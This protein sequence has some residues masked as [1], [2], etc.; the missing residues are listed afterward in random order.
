MIKQIFF[1]LV[2]FFPIFNIYAWDTTPPTA[3]EL[4]FYD[5]DWN[6]KID[7]IYIKFNET[8]TW[9]LVKSVFRISSVAWAFKEDSVSSTTDISSDILSSLIIWT[10]KNILKVRI[11]DFYKTWTGLIITN[12]TY[13]ELR[14]KNNLGVWITDLAW[15]EIDLSLTDSF[16]EYNT[17]KV[18]YWTYEEIWCSWDS[19][20]SIEIEK[21]QI[22]FNWTAL[23]IPLIANNF[24]NIW[25]FELRFQYD[26]SQ[27]N[28]QSVDS[29]ILNS[30]W[31]LQENFS[32][33]EINLIWDEDGW[34][35]LN[36]W[37]WTL[38]EI[39]CNVIWN[40]WDSSNLILTIP[41]L[42]DLDWNDLQ[43][44]YQ[45]TKTFFIQE[46][47]TIWWK[48]LN[49]DWSVFTWWTALLK[50]QDNSILEKISNTV[51]FLFWYLI[52]NQDYE[53]SAKINEWYTEDT[54]WTWDILKIQKHIIKSQEFTSWYDC[55]AADVN[56]DWKISVLDIIKIRKYLYN[57]T[58]LPSWDFKFYTWNIS[59]LNLWNL[60]EK[61]II[62]NFQSSTWNLIF[63]K[64]RMWNVEN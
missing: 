24:Q 14:V 47:F 44:N 57:K 8:L 50:K 27:L 29:E 4:R 19:C 36:F 42:W 64:I 1:L 15:N 49:P 21:N 52:A 16:N 10:S 2:L 32:D 62:N 7:T 38:L 33:W 5:S 46:N 25:W 51:W 26:N 60:Q 41:E 23:K 37:S 20:I 59:C 54:V 56:Q 34:N 53:L 61:I 9:T 45:D 6:Q 63:T 11:T 35:P 40:I 39:N 3:E 18:F 13:S 31:D 30:Q 43:S 17:S 12:W 58:P 55:A 28:C 48:I 22:W